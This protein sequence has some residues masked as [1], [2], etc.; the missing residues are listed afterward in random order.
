MKKLFILQ[1]CLFF[2]LVLS[3]Q[4]S[5]SFKYQALI[6]DS[7][8]HILS[9]Q[10]ISLKISLLEAN[11]Q[12][13]PRF[14]ESFLVTTSSHGIINI[15]I[16]TGDVISGSMEAVKWGDSLY[17]IKTEIDLDGGENYEFMGVSQVLSVP[18][19]L[20]ALNSGDTTRWR[21]DSTKLY[22]NHGKI[23][24]GTR[25]PRNLLHLSNDAFLNQGLPG[26][27][28]SNSGNLG[29]TWFLGIDP[30]ISS[31]GFSIVSDSSLDLPAVF[32]SK[33]GQVGIG[34]TDPK[35]ALDVQGRLYTTDGIYFPDSTFI[36]SAEAFWGTA[37]NCIFKD[38]GNVVIGSSGCSQYRL[39][40]DPTL[41]GNGILI[42]N[43]PS[44]NESGAN[45]IQYPGGFIRQLGYFNA[46]ENVT[47]GYGLQL[48]H[49]EFS[50]T[51][52]KWA[53]IY[54]DYA[55]PDSNKY[56]AIFKSGNVG[57][58]TD[59]PDQKLQVEGNSFFNGN[60]GIN[61]PNPEYSLDI[62]GDLRMKD[63]L[64]GDSSSIVK[65]FTITASQ[66]SHS[67]RIIM[68]KGSDDSNKN[69]KLVTR[70]NGII[71]F[72]TD[73]KIRMQVRD[74]VVVLGKPETDKFV[75]LNV[76]G[77][78]QAREVEVYIGYWWD[79]VFEPDY[80]LPSLEEVESFISKNKHLPGI[81]SE[82]EILEE[83]VNLAEMDGLL[84]KKI[85]ELTLYMI[86]LKNENTHLALEIEKLKQQSSQS[87]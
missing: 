49:N 23:G 17:F 81:P 61:N 79:H 29:N 11:F 3:S 7:A 33:N 9:D 48:L 76:N 20:W 78:I 74:T 27:N 40:I 30:D 43:I 72:F 46:E 10:E 55:N 66:H 84:L 16:G 18:M 4:I 42:N 8:N 60:V 44:I 56:A 6:R 26:I 70:E 52:S 19:A 68:G 22:Y 1:F 64:I 13:E 2:S 63:E 65:K 50:D 73:S 36:N 5:D 39:Q 58:G 31:D 67:T 34:T 59:K 69:I 35:H 21:K 71:S 83:G 38:T 87:K 28:V 62:T 54:V 57:I 85:E 32:I 45:S 53:A 12:G 75:D 41:S 86:E 14:E 24:I 80:H 51:L 77:K 15:N 25:Q 37:E 47:M 82:K